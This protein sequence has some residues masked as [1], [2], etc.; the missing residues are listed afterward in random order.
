MAHSLVK[1]YIHIVFSTKKRENII[2]EDFD[3]KLYNYLSKIINSTDS[4]VLKI[5]GYTDHIHILCE[6]SKNYA[7]SNFMQLLKGASSKWVNDNKFTSSNF[8]WQSGYGA[9]S[10][11]PQDID[12]IINYIDNQKIHH[13]TVS[14]QNELL[15]FLR[16]YNVKYNEKYLWD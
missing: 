10:I 5:G 16:K 14:Y 11:R 15:T 6:L 8:H 4:T 9:F 13:T 12:I 1:N 7:L 2:T 3:Y